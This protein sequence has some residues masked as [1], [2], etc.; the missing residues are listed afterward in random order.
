MNCSIC[1]EAITKASGSTTLSCEHTF[2]FRCIHTWFSKQVDQEMTQSCPCCRDKGST[3]DRCHEEEEEEEETYIDTYFEA[4]LT[5]ED[6]LSIRLDV[7]RMV[8]EMAAEKIQAFVRGTLARK[9]YNATL[10]LLG[11][12]AI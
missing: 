9:K 6:M 8:E 12:G 3:L 10:R 2:H 4:L 7:E 11:L 1:F 5:A